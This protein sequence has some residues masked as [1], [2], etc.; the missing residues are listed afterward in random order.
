MAPF[1]CFSKFK[2]KLVETKKYSQISGSM[3]IP[4]RGSAQ[5]GEPD[6]IY[7]QPTGVVDHG[8]GDASYGQ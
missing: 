6:P 8:S 1:F 4:G 5:S 3:F 2:Y 7:R